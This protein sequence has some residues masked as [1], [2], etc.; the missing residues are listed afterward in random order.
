MKINLK[1]MFT[2]LFAGS[3]L[4]GAITACNMNANT[5]SGGATTDVIVKV[6]P[7]E[8]SDNPVQMAKNMKIGWNLGNAFDANGVINA[9]NTSDWAY[10][11]GLKLEY[12]WLPHKQ[13]TSRNLIKAVRAAGF[14]TIRIPVSW[15]NHMSR[16]STDYTI[17]S[18]WMN[19]V[20]T[21][22]DWSLEEGMCVIINIHHDN[23]TE[24]EIA[25]N[26]GFCLSTDEDIQNKSI[27]FIEN[28][29]SQISETFKDY[30]NKLV[31][32]LLNEPRCVGTAM[33]W[34]FWDNEEGNNAGKEKV[35]CP[36]I[37][38]Y[39]QAALNVIRGTGGNNATRYVM[40]PGYAASPAY[41]S[42][43][44]LPV[45]PAVTSSNGKSR[46]LLAVHAYTPG[47][48]CLEGNKSDYSANKSYI[49]SSITSEFNNLKT[50]Y[51]SKGIGVVMGEA[52]ASDKNNLDSRVKWADYYFAKAAAAGIPVILWDN[53]QAVSM[54]AEAGGENHGYFNR[55]TC[56][57]TWP[58]MIEAMMKT[59]YDAEDISTKGDSGSDTPG[60]TLAYTINY[61]GINGEAAFT[62]ESN[63]DTVY[64]KFSE[65]VE[66]MQ[67]VIKTN[68]LKEDHGSWKEYY[69]TYV[70]VTT[71]ENTINLS[72]KLNYIK[73]E[74]SGIDVGT[75][76]TVGI[77]NTKDSANTFKVVKSTVKKTD[78]SVVDI[79][80]SGDGW[81]ATVAK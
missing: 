67:F 56:V 69:C 11:E 70:P 48:F 80:P 26:P 54:G 20:K 34:G 63:W 45:E 47:D 2:A 3:L 72:D 44:S 46:I 43:Y 73:A 35:Y 38:K 32:E 25:L 23:L 50:N 57:Q 6:E 1:K 81:N 40:A 33:E 75:I 4:F 16:T 66:G 8:V 49:E 76:A 12:N 9:S 5:G 36:I 78:S 10:N 68:V 71:A 58:S 14:N 61:T 29:W 74:N 18:A 37:T 22:V 53:E 31:F 65:V 7:F 64:V 13:A 62:A 17:D 60:D 21:V 42:D 27:A 59:I 77:Q 41:L 19:R 52:S 30:D 24:A 39:E 55:V 51:V 79:I 28:V 15:H